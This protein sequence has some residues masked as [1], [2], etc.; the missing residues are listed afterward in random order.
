MS[1][2]LI[3]KSELPEWGEADEKIKNQFEEKMEQDRL[4]LVSAKNPNR[5][6]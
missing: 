1:L 3:S 5:T 4:H 6:V 2:E